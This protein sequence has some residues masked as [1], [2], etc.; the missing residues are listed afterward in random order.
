[1][2][3]WH[4]LHEMLTETTLAQPIMSSYPWPNSMLYPRSTD[5]NKSISKVI[6]FKIQPTIIFDCFNS[7]KFVLVNLV[8]KFPRSSP[9][10]GDL[11]NLKV[12]E[13]VF[14]VL[15]CFLELFPVFFTLECSVLIKVSTT[16][17]ILSNLGML[18]NIDNFW[19]LYPN[20]FHW[21]SKF[22]NNAI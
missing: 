11:L 21:A 19:I 8:H 4:L 7:W 2:K 20:I 3:L 1:M 10:V 17:H 9:F 6:D 18:C 15:N 16:V 5:C 14:H 13:C 12:E 22:K